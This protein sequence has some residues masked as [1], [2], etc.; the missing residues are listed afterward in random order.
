MYRRIFI[1]SLVSLCFSVVD[2]SAQETVKD[3]VVVQPVQAEDS[4][5]VKESVP[6]QD[7]SP[8]VHEQV[9]KDKDSAQQPI[10][11]HVGYNEGYSRWGYDRSAQPKEPESEAMHMRFK[12]TPIDGDLGTFCGKLADRELLYL[13]SRNGIGILQG[14]FAGIDDV[15]VFVYTSNKLIWKVSVLF[16]A[17]ENWQQMKTQYL[18][19]KKSLI[20]KYY[21]KPVCTEY[22]PAH[23]PE[24]TGREHNAFKDETAVWKSVYSLDDGT[25]ILSVKATPQGGK[26]K[27]NLLLEYE[28]GLNKILK[29]NAFMEDL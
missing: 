16:P 10:I 28:D 29:D 22:F 11:Q 24:G 25:I 18:L 17:N 8:A 14:K 12:G 13:G 9:E 3:T 1:L 5:V 6:V 26:G 7:L 19:F 2:L 4:V 21:V 27:M 23:T 20:Q 15:N